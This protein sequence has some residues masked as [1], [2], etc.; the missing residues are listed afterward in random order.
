MLSK[1]E[2]DGRLYQEDA[3]YHL[4][5]SG[6]EALLRINSHGN[7]VLGSPVLTAFR[8]LTEDTVV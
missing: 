6:E 1:I 7:Q 2:S 4:V 3:M 8:R 5:V